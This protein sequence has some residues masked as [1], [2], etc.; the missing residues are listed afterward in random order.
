M[1]SVKYKSGTGFLLATVGRRV[2]F[3]WSTFLREHG[4]T[5]AEFTAL[6]VL[7]SRGSCTQ[8]QLAKDCEVDP[9][10]MVATIKKLHTRGWVTIVAD[11]SDG[12][13]KVLHATPGGHEVLQ[14][15]Y[16]D[17]R[18]IE[19]AFMRSISPDGKQQL[20]RLLMILKKD[21]D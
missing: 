10:N 11:P 9:R 15:L 6:A 14:A 18:P 4:I 20:Q 21:S 7:D 16:A 8:G 19:E 12:R 3:L 5:T 13:A 2:E 17:L 1:S